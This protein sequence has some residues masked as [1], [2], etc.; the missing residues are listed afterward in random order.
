MPRRR[1]EKLAFG[2]RIYELGRCSPSSLGYAPLSLDGGGAL[3]EVVQ[4]V[5]FWS[6]SKSWSGLGIESWIQPGL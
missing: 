2:L 5:R 6:R 4:K 1:S 3:I